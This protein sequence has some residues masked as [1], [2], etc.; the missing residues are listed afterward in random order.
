[1]KYLLFVSFASGLKHNSQ[2]KTLK[3]VYESFQQLI[4]EESLDIKKEGFLSLVNL[5]KHLEVED[6]YVGQVSNGTWYHIQPYPI[7]G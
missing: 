3:E 1:M 5:K 7:F 4:G 6:D 2:Y